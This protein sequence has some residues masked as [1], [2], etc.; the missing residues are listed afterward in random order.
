MMQSRVE[1]GT[2]AGKGQTT[3]RELRREEETDKEEERDEQQT[4]HELELHGAHGQAKGG[5]GADDSIDRALATT[6]LLARRKERYKWRLVALI[7]V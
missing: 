4:V 5:S 3:T 6:L 7:S 2:P 1:W